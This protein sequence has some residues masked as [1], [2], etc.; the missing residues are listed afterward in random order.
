M[1]QATR[2][3]HAR[4]S[5]ERPLSLERRN[6]KKNSA[7]IVEVDCSLS[8][9]RRHVQPVIWQFPKINCCSPLSN[10]QALPRVDCP[11]LPRAAVQWKCTKRCRK[12]FVFLILLSNR[13]RAKGPVQLFLSWT[14]SG[15]Q[16]RM[17]RNK[18]AKP[19]HDKFHHHCWWCWATCI[20][21]GRAFCYETHSAVARRKFLR[22]LISILSALS[23]SNQR[24]SNAADCEYHVN[25][26]RLVCVALSNAFRLGVERRCGVE[27]TI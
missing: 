13:F 19:V 26:S 27:R 21:R 9:R 10:K 16:R 8:N 7:F 25:D 2:W 15:K 3:W 4:P 24:A 17:K 22:I 11:L 20:M 6:Q 12:K 14:C 23:A 5:S 1:W 18:K